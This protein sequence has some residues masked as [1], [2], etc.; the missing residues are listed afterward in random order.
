M[1]KHILV[2]IALV[3]LS[4]VALSVLAHGGYT[5]EGENL[6][7]YNIK[8]RSIKLLWTASILIAMCTAFSL[9]LYHDKRFK[10]Y[11]KHLFLGM[12]I[13]ALI[14]T[15]YLT[16]GTIYLNII[17]E[18]GGP[19][20]WHADFEVWKCG[21]KLDPHDPTGLSNRIG[22]PLFHEHNDFRIHV[23]G[24]VLEKKDV[25]LGHFFKVIGGELTKDKMHMPLINNQEVTVNNGDT[26]NGKPAKL[27]TFVYRVTN[28]SYV[29]DWDFVQ[30]KIENFP[31]YVLAPYAYVPPGDCI[32]VEFDEE[33]EKTDKICETYKVAKQR[34]ELKNHG[35]TE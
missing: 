6:T 2:L 15:G 22:T 23:E 9:F 7:Y 4:T 11:K 8:S 31:E 13:P 30:Q 32:I 24:V 5:E 29:K 34:G 33:K 18:S 16:Y 21:E 19:V 10:K 20:H 28:P 17:S 26:C 1:K 12:V 25:N 3:I 14:A 27:Q 35:G